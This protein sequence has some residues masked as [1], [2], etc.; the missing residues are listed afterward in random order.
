MSW[1]IKT[2]G[3]YING[4]LTVAGVTQFNSNVGVGAASSAWNSNYNAIDIGTNGSISGRVGS[5]NTVDLASNGFRNSAGNWVYKLAGSNTA[6][7]YQLDGSTGGHYW[8]SGA[9][10]TANNTIAGFSTPT[11]T[12]DPNGVL[13]LPSN[14][15][16]LQGN[17]AGWPTKMILGNSDTGGYGVDI[18]W[19]LNDYSNNA[20]YSPITLR[21]TFSGGVVGGS[22][23]FRGKRLSTSSIID[24]LTI[25][26]GG[27]VAVNSGNL[28]MGT[29]G[30]GIDFSAGSNAAGMT[31]ELL[32]D[33]EEGTWTPALTFATPGTLSINYGNRNGNY[34]KVG[35]LVTARFA[36]TINP[37]Q[38]S[39]G[40]AS[41]ALI[42]GGLPFNIGSSGA[43][44]FD[45]AANL[46][47]QNTGSFVLANP[48]GGTN[49]I[50]IESA[51]VSGSRI[52]RDYAAI[53]AANF[54]SINSGYI[55]VSAVIQFTV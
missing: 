19:T 22:I 35:N 29:A 5:S 2:P 16:Q 39:K 11:M 43:Y 12:L 33:Y 7:R 18:A 17:Q 34:T 51:S 50:Y 13:L 23:I 41:G 21:S 52:L 8:Y 9:A 30:K 25:Y 36:I 53:T 31:S 27:D 54:A 42:I 4:P 26:G 37:A 38:F 15:L 14:Y 40:T 24:V 6:A 47:D 49:Q 28:V 45:L 1:N 3:D 20:F 46:A 48:V 44:Y 10:G 55:T 32:N